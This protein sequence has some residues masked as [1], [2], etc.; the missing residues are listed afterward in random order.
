MRIVLSIDRILDKIYAQSALRTYMNQ[1]ARKIPM[2]T[3][4]NRQVLAQLVV[5]TFAD[6]ILQL[7]P[8]VAD[9]DLA[10]VD[11]DLLEVEFRSEF[12]IISSTT[13]RKA[14]ETTIADNALAIVLTDDD[15][16][17]AREIAR[18]AET[19]L[20]NLRVLLA[21]PPEGLHISPYFQC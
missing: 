16:T 6:I 8:F 9:L 17:I 11:P 20:E 4:D 12:E 19:N 1:N 18:R 14:L 2:L 7:M 10:E 13:L 5:G 21:L 15:T 3:P